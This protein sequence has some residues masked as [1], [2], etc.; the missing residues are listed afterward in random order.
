MTYYI[1]FKKFIFLWVL[2]ALGIS[3]SLYPMKQD[4][5][6]KHKTAQTKHY[7]SQLQQQA[8]RCTKISAAFARSIPLHYKRWMQAKTT[9]LFMYAI[10]KNYPRFCRLLRFFGA[11]VTPETPGMQAIFDQIIASGN[12]QLID[13]LIENNIPIDTRTSSGNTAFIEAIRAHNT[14]MALFFLEKGANINALDRERKTSLMF[15]ATTGDIL[16]INFLLE[17]GADINTYNHEGKTALIYAVESNIP[18]IVRS[19]IQA[20]ANRLLNDSRGLNAV[21]YAINK[22][23]RC[24]TRDEQQNN[25][26]IQCMLCPERLLSRAI[27]AGDIPNA[28]LL[29]EQ[30][31]NPNTQITDP[32]TL[33]PTTPL[34]LAFTN[35]NETMARM[36]L[37]HGA[38]P[39]ADLQDGSP[40]LH[41]I[42]D[43][44]IANLLLDLGVPINARHNNTGETALLNAVKKNQYDIVSLLLARG[45]DTMIPDSQGSFPI[46]YAK[47]VEIAKRLLPF[48]LD[49]N[50]QNEHGETPLMIAIRNNEIDLV[51]LY[52]SQGARLD[53]VNK[54]KLNAIDIAKQ[55]YAKMGWFSSK[56]TKSKKIQERLSSNVSIAEP[57]APPAP[58]EQTL[59]QAL[60]EKNK[61]YAQTIIEQGIQL[62]PDLCAQKVKSLGTIFQQ[63]T[64]DNDSVLLSLL[65]QAGWAIATWTEQQRISA[66]HTAAKDGNQPF[67][68][69]LIQHGTNV[70]AK[71]HEQKTALMLA[72]EK[73]NTQIINLLKRAKANPNETDIHGRRAIDYTNNPEIKG[74]VQPYTYPEL[75]GIY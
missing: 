36:L 74:L 29:V 50:V 5:Y 67:I 26:L 44:K 13:L 55:E 62:S 15:A 9:N 37:A 54:E 43:P 73:N 56:C 58:T 10:R 7:F 6:T 24:I 34:I 39:P 70:N 23:S 38:H 32:K 25:K 57:S 45:A 31:I 22:E 51:D 17:H 48:I 64:A 42:T 59:L 61:E 30:Y 21:N 4:F 41:L 35:Q 11:Q 75:F 20:G 46:H 3:N 60:I 52:L 33:T 49:I 47:N 1:F 8:I 65:A 68:E 69:Q 12:R 66:L 14:Q 19:L 71:D 40:I 28:Q 53:Y 27:N 2:L 16:L 72:A 18:N 63:A